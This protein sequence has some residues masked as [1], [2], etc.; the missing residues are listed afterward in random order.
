MN[1][2]YAHIY[3]K[4]C[5]YNYILKIIRIKISRIEPET[6]GLLEIRLLFRKCNLFKKIDF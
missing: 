2:K 3:L 6:K 4:K 5:V 1:F